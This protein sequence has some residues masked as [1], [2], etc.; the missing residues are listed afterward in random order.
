MISSV[1]I[2]GKVLNLIRVFY[3]AILIMLLV[4]LKVFID[5]Y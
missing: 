4:G 2:Q 1:L 5:C 3:I